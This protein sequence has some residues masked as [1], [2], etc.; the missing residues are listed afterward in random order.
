MIPFLVF[1]CLQ[2]EKSVYLT[3]V[4]SPKIPVSVVRTDKADAYYQDKLYTESFG[5]SIIV[6]G[7]Q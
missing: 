5:V 7:L 2:S 6:N 3:L 1:L 4:T